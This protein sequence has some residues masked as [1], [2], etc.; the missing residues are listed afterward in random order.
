[1][2]NPIKYNSAFTLIELAIVLVIV[3]LLIGGVLTGRDLINQARIA[4]A[5]RQLQDYNTSINTYYL[6]YKALPG[7]HAG[8]TSFITGAGGNG[9]GDGRVLS[10]YV[11]SAPR[12]TSSESTSGA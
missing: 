3:G 7:D 10:L 1:M 2:K 5:V 11:Y 12:C 8:A 9:N 6:K 4:A